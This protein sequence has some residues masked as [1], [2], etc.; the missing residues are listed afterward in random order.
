MEIKGVKFGNVK[1]FKSSNQSESNEA[2]KLNIKAIYYTDINGVI[3]FDEK[4]GNLWRQ[5]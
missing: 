5:Q 4:N 3:G 1:V 2:A